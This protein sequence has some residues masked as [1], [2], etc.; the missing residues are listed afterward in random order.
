MTSSSGPRPS[1]SFDGLRP[2]K[3]FSASFDWS[4][5]RTDVTILKIFA[6]KFGENIDVFAQTTASYCTKLIVTLVFEKNA[7]FVAE[8][9]Q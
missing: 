5:P 7:N 9:C 2:S 1:A 3:P 4:R 6:E 8:N